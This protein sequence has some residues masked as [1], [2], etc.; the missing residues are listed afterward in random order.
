MGK[1]SKLQ[2]NGASPLNKTGRNS[3]SHMSKKKIDKIIKMKNLMLFVY[4]LVICSTFNAQKIFE[5]I[6]KGDLKKVEIWLNKNADKL[7]QRFPI[8]NNRGISDSLHI[9]EYAA[10][11]NKKEILS[12]FIQ[13]KG[14]FDNFTE[15]ISD[16]LGSNIQNC[17]KE[18]LKM[19]IDAGALVNGRCRMCK[20]APPIAIA[21]GYNCF[22]SYKILLENGAKLI[23]ENS[24]YDVIH[25]ASQNDSLPFLVNLIE[26]EFL[27][28]NQEDELWKTNAAFYAALKNLENMKY[29]IE[30]GADYGKFDSEG[31][32]I[33]YYAGNLEIFNFLEN[34][35][36]NEDGRLINDLIN[37]KSMLITSII[38]K[39]DKELFDYFVRHYPKLI[40]PSGNS[41]N[42]LFSLLETTKNNE[43]FFNELMK[44]KM[45]LYK[46]DKY[47]MDLKYYAKKM[48]RNELLD[49]IK[50][51]EKS[52]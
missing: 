25:A 23:N 10:Y 32:S 18:T 49:I 7:N 44:N 6:K 40:L 2:I 33:L 14:K 31:Y 37:K 50:R 29:L 48:K 20:K 22:D 16:G 27:D 42:P 15:W 46:V 36:I 19:L 38:S 26:N 17:D 47:G 41:D 4:F 43:Y 13:N 28:V 5:H 34:R 1:L 11:H 8:T 24:G 9:I 39:D 3:K 45:D 35:L 30:K 12:L 51:Y 52:L 21:I